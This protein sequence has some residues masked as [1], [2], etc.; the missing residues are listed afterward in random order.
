MNIKISYPITLDKI[1]NIY[2][3]KI[4]IFVDIG[5]GKNYALKVCTPQF[6][7]SYMEKENLDFIPASPPNIIV[8]VLK[9]DVIERAIQACCDYDAYYLKKYAEM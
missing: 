4:D 1:N 7:Y 2:N 3:D 5:D 6:Y 9:Y 8:E